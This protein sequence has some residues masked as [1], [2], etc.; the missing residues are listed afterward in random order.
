[1]FLHDVN[2]SIHNIQSKQ[3]AAVDLRWL[4][5]SNIILK[6]N[7]I[8]KIEKRDLSFNFKAFLKQHFSIP[9]FFFTKY[10]DIVILTV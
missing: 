10:I 7:I 6:N 2:E 9:G 4:A 1:M 8:V 3:N 5:N